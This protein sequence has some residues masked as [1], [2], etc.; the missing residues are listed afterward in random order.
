MPSYKNILQ[1]LYGLER[2][3]IR[4]GLARVNALLKL[5]GNP[6]K[7]FPIIH[8]GGT[9]GKGS[10]SAMLASILQEAGC[11]VGLYTS[12]HLVR[13][14]ERIRIDGK[15]ITNRKIVELTERIRNNPPLIPPFLKGGEG[16]LTFFEFTTAM[17]FLYFAE[18]KVDIAVIEVG[19]GGRLDA[20]NVCKPLVS[21]ITNVSR[22]HEDILGKGI[23]KI[24]VEKAGIIKENGILITAAQQPSALKIFDRICRQKNAKICR[25]GK[26]FFVK[27]VKGSRGQ[28]VKGLYPHGSTGAFSF[29]GRRWIYKNLKTNLL[30]RHQYKNAGL[31]LF[32]LEMI[33]KKGFKITE[34]AVRTGL[35]NV[36]CNGRLQ[37]I[38]KE[39]TIVLD[40][41]HNPAGAKVLRDSLLKEFCYKKL[42][43]VI[44]IMAD[45]DIKGFLSNIAQIADLVILTKPN[46]P[47][48]AKKE[49]LVTTAKSLAK[50]V[51]F[52]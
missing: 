37:I 1:Y 41:A 42:I 50:N 40:S 45:K 32:A 47:R 49:I 48:A 19:L 52:V 5:L 10:V 25:I 7:K 44:G 6:H 22:E 14:N 51:N 4:L 27:G 36:K 29:K 12:P 16:G 8:V 33:G 24:A 26:D 21:I 31:A 39:P 2:F 3:G 38:S 20:T 46:T 13:F 23:K 34:D 35:K 17:A 43:L 18:E 9:N 28:G 30:G 11:K 15:E